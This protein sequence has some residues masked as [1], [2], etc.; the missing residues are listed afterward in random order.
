MAI[1]LTV[2]HL[3]SIGLVGLFCIMGFPHLLVFS[4]VGS[5]YPST[6]MASRFGRA[7]QKIYSACYLVPCI[8]LFVAISYVYVDNLRISLNRLV[9]IVVR[10]I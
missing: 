6:G 9:E 4:E 1:C 7:R 8:R 2:V 3:S 10:T 5:S